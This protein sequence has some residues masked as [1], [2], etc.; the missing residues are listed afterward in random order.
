MKCYRHCLQ[1]RVERGDSFWTWGRASGNCSTVPW[2]GAGW[3]ALWKQYLLSMKVWLTLRA[4]CVSFQKDP[5]YRKEECQVLEYFFLAAHFFGL[6]IREGMWVCD[7]I[8]T[9]YTYILP[10]YHKHIYMF[11]HIYVCISYVYMH[12]C[13]HMFVCVCNIMWIFYTLMLF[14]IMYMLYNILI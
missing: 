14:I 4:I 3:E 1:G 7:I 2:R 12:I 8:F 13:I 5:F 9:Q 11:V 10:H 6:F